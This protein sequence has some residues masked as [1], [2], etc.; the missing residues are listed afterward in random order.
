MWQCEKRHRRAS[1]LVHFEVCATSLAMEA[2][3]QDILNLRVNKT[4]GSPNLQWEDETLD[5]LRQSYHSIRHQ[6]A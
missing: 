4:M 2:L 5:T 3:Q 6:K 1:E